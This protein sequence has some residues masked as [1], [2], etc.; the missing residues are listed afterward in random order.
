MEKKK[1]TIPCVEVDL[2]FNGDVLNLSDSSKFND[3]DNY[4]EDAYL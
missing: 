2:L 1:Y 4:L 3:K